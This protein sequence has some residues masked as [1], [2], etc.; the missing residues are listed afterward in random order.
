[1]SDRM[2]GIVDLVF[3]FGLVLVLIALDLW[4]MN[5]EDAR[6]RKRKQN[7]SAEPKG[8]KTDRDG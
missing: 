6:D 7:S 4:W 8:Q 2:M 1:M 5:R 3:P